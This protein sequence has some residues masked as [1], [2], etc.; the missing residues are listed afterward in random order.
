MGTSSATRF[1]AA[2]DK[3]RNIGKPTGTQRGE[4]CQCFL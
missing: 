1:Q 4:Q 2:K 3:V